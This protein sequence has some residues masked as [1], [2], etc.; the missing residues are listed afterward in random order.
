MHLLIRIDCFFKGYHSKEGHSEEDCRH[1]QPKLVPKR[2]RQLERWRKL[3]LSQGDQ[4]PG[5]QTLAQDYSLLRV[6][7]EPKRNLLCILLFFVAK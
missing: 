7:P 1:E 5:A 4:I 2:R 3:S 6:Q